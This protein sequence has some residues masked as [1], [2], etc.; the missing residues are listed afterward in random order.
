MSEQARQLR[1][2]KA[3]RDFMKTL[4]EETVLP[5]DFENIVQILVDLTLSE[6]GSDARVTYSCTRSLSEYT[7][8]AKGFDKTA[9]V[10]DL[11]TIFLSK[12]RDNDKS[13][14][15]EVTVHWKDCAL[16]V[17]VKSINPRTQKTSKTY[18]SSR[19]AGRPVL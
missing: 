18:G 19:V 9:S 16:S 6:S 10:G 11:A 7:V 13:T 14:V 3:V 12:N 8:V 17:I 15:E 5:I 4:P 1:V 2:E